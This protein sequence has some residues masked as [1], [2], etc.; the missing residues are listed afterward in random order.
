MGGIAFQSQKR[1]FDFSRLPE[2]VETWL[3]DK[4]KGKNYSDN[5]Y[6]IGLSGGY[7]FNWVPGK[8]WTIGIVGML[9]PSINYG[10]LNS[11]RK[12]Y[13]FRMNYRLN[14]GTVWN[15]N[16]WFI[17]VTVKTDASM[18]YSHSTLASGLMN[19]ES[20]FGFRFNL[21]NSKKR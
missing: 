7:G 10:Y 8:N 5:G 1:N 16:Q 19:I 15:H 4:W 14:L 18:V 11:E 17:G 2:P 20:K 6:N 13:S 3:P 12:G 9:I 21:S